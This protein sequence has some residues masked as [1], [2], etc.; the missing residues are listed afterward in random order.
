[1]LGAL[2]EMYAITHG[3]WN[4]STPNFGNIPIW[5]F[6][7]WGNAGLFIYRTAVEFERLGFHK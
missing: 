3:V 4:Y 6:V 2:G 1:M 7:L 5:L